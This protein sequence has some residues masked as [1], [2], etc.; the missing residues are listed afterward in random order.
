MRDLLSGIHS[1]SDL[2]G[3]LITRLHSSSAMPASR[4]AVLGWLWRT[5]AQMYRLVAVQL[6][7]VRT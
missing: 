5:A 7:T 4:T 6:A 2:I 3:L 1:I